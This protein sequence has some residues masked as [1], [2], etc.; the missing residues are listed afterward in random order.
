MTGEDFIFYGPSGG[1]WTP[2]EYFKG[3]ALSRRVSKL[4]A[5]VTSWK[6]QGWGNRKGELFVKLMRRNKV[7]AEK[8]ELFGIAEHHEMA[9]DVEL[10]KEEA[11]VALAKPGDH[12]LFMRNA[13]GGGGH[14]LVVKGFRAVA[15]LLD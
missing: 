3:P 13:G 2:E 6:D 4:T 10:G 12:Y 8:R 9:A 15:S 14:K 5:Q 7:V 1:H 11:V